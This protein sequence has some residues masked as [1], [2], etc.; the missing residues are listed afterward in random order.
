M[1]SL[2]THPAMMVASMSGNIYVNRQLK[3]CTFLRCYLPSYT[4]ESPE[5]AFYILNKHNWCLYL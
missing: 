2:V 5:K 3:L 4:Y 1:I